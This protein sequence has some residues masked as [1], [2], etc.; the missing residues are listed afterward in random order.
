[1]R[2]GRGDKQTSKQRLPTIGRVKYV[3]RLL[4]RRPSV[5]AI[6]DRLHNEPSYYDKVL[7]GGPNSGAMLLRQIVFA[8]LVCFAPPSCCVSC[9]I[10]L[11]SVN[12]HSS[13]ENTTRILAFAPTV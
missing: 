6:T 10:V 9:F 7:N 5:V 3:R 1:M 12:K 13:P 8:S 11:A 4:S 2:G